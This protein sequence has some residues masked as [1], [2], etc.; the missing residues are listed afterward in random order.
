MGAL[1]QRFQFFKIG[2]PGEQPPEP[3]D[4]GFSA[5][6]RLCCNRISRQP[7]LVFALAAD[8]HLVLAICL[9]AGGR[10]VFRGSG[11]GVR[12]SFAAYGGE[13]WKKTVRLR[14]K[15]WN[16]PILLRWPDSVNEA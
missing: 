3:P 8:G 1:N 4:G 9:S 10:G 11:C 2:A 6:L 12:R 14:Q 15:Y 13:L 16:T 5:I 7:I